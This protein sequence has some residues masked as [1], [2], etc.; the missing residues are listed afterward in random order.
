MSRMLW[1]ATQILLGDILEGV[2]VVAMS[3]TLIDRD[4]GLTLAANRAD[5]SAAL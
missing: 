3:H 4:A 2:E 1:I 5:L